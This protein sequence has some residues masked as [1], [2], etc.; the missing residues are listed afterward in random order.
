MSEK[1]EN[2]YRAGLYH[3]VFAYLKQK[4]VVTRAELLE[5]TK[6]KL[7]KTDEEAQAAVTVILSPRKA[8]KRGDCRGNMS[9]QGHLY[10]LDKLGRQVKAGVK[11]PQKFRLR[12][13]ETVLEPRKRV[14]TGEVNQTK[15]P[16]KVEVTADVQ[17]ETKA[18][19]DVKG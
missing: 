3:N 18:D 11:D 4:Q 2:P 7:G 12:W 15:T 14:V 10:F 9:A 17:T 19:A 5:H 13:R 1:H 6:T 8:S 16:V